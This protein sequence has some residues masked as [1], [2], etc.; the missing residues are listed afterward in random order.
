MPDDDDIPSAAVTTNAVLGALRAVAVEQPS[1]LDEE[2]LADPL[3]ETPGAL[4]VALVVAAD[5][6]DQ[7]EAAGVPDTDTLFGAMF[8]DLAALLGPVADPRREATLTP[9]TMTRLLRAVRFVRYDIQAVETVP[10]SSA[11]GV[12]GLMLIALQAISAPCAGPADVAGVVASFIDRNLPHP[13]IP[14][15]SSSPMIRFAPDV[16]LDA[17]A[18]AVFGDRRPGRNDPCWCGSGT[19]SKHCHGSLSTV[20]LAQVVTILWHAGAL[21]VSNLG[22]VAPPGRQLPEAMVPLLTVDNRPDPAFGEVLRR[23]GIA[24]ITAAPTEIGGG[25]PSDVGV[26][27]TIE[28]RAAFGIAR[29]DISWSEPVPYHFAVTVPFTADTLVWFEQVHRYGGMCVAASA[30][31]TPDLSEIVSGSPVLWVSIAADQTASLAA[32]ARDYLRVQ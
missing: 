17:M 32:A 5:A 26:D 3:L 8:S 31:E 18:G 4:L 6:V 22:F 28:V 20:E 23:V 12:V 10:T 27:T 29:F 19:K 7:M 2:A 21:P 9:E 14:I 15:P 25:F 16:D 1:L 11:L 13:H 24:T 30:A